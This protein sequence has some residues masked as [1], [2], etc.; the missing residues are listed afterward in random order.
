VPFVGSVYVPLVEVTGFPDGSSNAEML[1]VPPEVKNGATIC[2][3]VPVNVNEAPGPT[4]RTAGAAS[5]VI[6]V[7]LGVTAFDGLDAGPVP[8]AL[9]ALTVNV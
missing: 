8:T 7:G 2:P 1:R 3:A 9:V 6:G 5:T 4:V